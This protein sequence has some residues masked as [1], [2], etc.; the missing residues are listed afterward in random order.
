MLFRCNQGAPAHQ[1]I[2]FILYV[3][4]VIIAVIGI[5]RIGLPCFDWS[6]SAHANSYDALTLTLSSTVSKSILL[7][8]PQGTEFG[9]YMM[10]YDVIDLMVCSFELAHK[11]PGCLGTAWLRQDLEV[12]LGNFARRT[13]SRKQ[14]G[15][16]HMALTR[17][18][19]ST[20]GRRRNRGATEASI[21][22]FENEV[23]AKIS[24]ITRLLLFS[25]IFI[26]FPLQNYWFGFLSGL[27]SWDE[28]MGF[29]ALPCEIQG[30]R[31]VGSSVGQPNKPPPIEV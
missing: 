4:I 17:A 2:L 5:T 19:G 15:Q 20:I 1:L 16:R 25:F 12:L 10:S 6:L 21:R 7:Q 9:P 23:Q 27:V 28:T 14:L 18:C 30:D 11:I 29:D 31:H 3:G 24:S 22:L 13:L 26:H 8:N